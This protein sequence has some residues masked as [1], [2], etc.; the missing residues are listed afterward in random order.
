[1]S[2]VFYHGPDGPGVEVTANVRPGW[3]V[4]GLIA[5]PKIGRGWVELT[6]AEARLVAAAL[7]KA[8]DETERDPI[9]GGRP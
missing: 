8:A 2:T 7:V 5:Q 6:P 9:L 3:S 4:V 1:M